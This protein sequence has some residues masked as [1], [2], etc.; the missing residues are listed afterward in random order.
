MRARDIDIHACVAP[1]ASGNL[2]LRAQATDADGR[3]PVSRVDAW[4]AG[5]EEWSYEVSDND[6]IDVGPFDMEFFP[7]THSVPHGFATAFHTPQGVV[8]HS[9]D[10]KLDMMPVDKRLTD[11]AGLGHLAGLGV[12]AVSAEPGHVVVAELELGGL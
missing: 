8:L 6:R 10:F 9:G 7:V 2:I 12:D 4:V 3:L 11:L 1:P 5:G